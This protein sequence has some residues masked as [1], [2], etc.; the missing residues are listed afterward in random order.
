MHPAKTTIVDEIK[1]WLDNSPYLIVTDYTGMTVE[2]FTEL[3]QRL[4]Q[5]E[6]ELH[7]VK[8]TFLRRALNDAGMPELN[9]ALKGQTAVVY[10]ESDVSAA[11]KALK[12]FASEFEKPEIRIGILDRSVLDVDQIK[13]IAE[14]PP[15]EVL[16]AKLMGLINTPATKLATL[17]NT[18]AT[19]LAQVIKANAE[20]GE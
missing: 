7:V 14:L 17:I 4:G 3:R 12:T 20:K 18:P 16:L 5:C 8:N 9:G 13:A 11:A 6:A 19:Q 2:Q 15:R 1:G 10:G